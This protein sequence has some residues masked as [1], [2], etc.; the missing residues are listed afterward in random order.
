MFFDEYDSEADDEL[1]I[2]PDVELFGNPFHPHMDLLHGDFDFDD[3]GDIDFDYDYYS[4]EDDEYFSDDE[5]HNKIFVSL[6]DSHVLKRLC[7]HRAFAPKRLPKARVARPETYE[8]L[9]RLLTEIEILLRTWKKRNAHALTAH[10]T[11]PNDP[12]APD[13]APSASPAARASDA[14]AARLPIDDH[15]DDAQSNRSL[16]YGVDYG[17]QDFEHE[18]DSEM[19][20]YGETETN[21][22]LTK[23]KYCQS[24]RMF[25]EAFK[26]NHDYETFYRFIH[27]AKKQV[28]DLIFTLFLNSVPPE[29]AGR[30]PSEVWEKIWKYTQVPTESKLHGLCSGLRTD[31]L[32]ESERLTDLFAAAGDLH[33][34]IFEILFKHPY[35]LDP[36]LM[37]DVLMGKVETN[38]ASY[39]SFM[40][41]R[42]QKR[43][44]TAFH[45]M[46]GFH[47]LRV[48]PQDEAEHEDI[49]NNGCEV[50]EENVQ[51]KRMKE[52]LVTFQSRKCR[53]VAPSN[54]LLHLRRGMLDIH[55]FILTGD[56][57]QN[58]IAF[59]E[60]SETGSF[61]TATI[62]NVILSRPVAK[63]HTGLTLLE[64]FMDKNESMP[65]LLFSLA[66]GRFAVANRISTPEKDNVEIIMWEFNPEGETM[67]VCRPE[68]CS[69]KVCDE[70]AS[71]PQPYESQDQFLNRRPCSLHVLDRKNN[72]RVD[73]MLCHRNNFSM[74][75]TLLFYDGVS[76][77]RLK[78]A[79]IKFT[80][81]YLSLECVK[82]GRAILREGNQEFFFLNLNSGKILD[83]YKMADLCKDANHSHEKDEVLDR[84]YYDVKMD[85][86]P[87]RN[88]F[89]I[90]GTGLTYFQLFQYEDSE[91][92]DGEGDQSDLLP[93][94]VLSGEDG[95][96]FGWSG[97]LNAYLSLYHGCIYGAPYQD[98]HLRAHTGDFSR[99]EE[100]VGSVNLMVYDLKT[101][102]LTPALSSLCRQSSPDTL[103]TCSKLLD[104]VLMNEYSRHVFIDFLAH[105]YLY[106]VNPNVMIL[107]TRQGF[108]QTDFHSSHTQAIE[109]EETILKDIYE[110]RKLTVKEKQ[111]LAL[112]QLHREKPLDEFIGTVTLW[113]HSFGFSKLNDHPEVGTVFIHLSAINNRNK[114]QLMSPGDVVKFRI[115]KSHD[116]KFQGV[117][118]NLISS[119]HEA[120][121]SGHR[122]SHHH[123]RG[124]GGRRGGGGGRGGQKSGRGSGASVERN[125]LKVE[126]H[127]VY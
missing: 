58:V 105:R 49:G 71:A 111:I 33:M 31:S 118:V 72:G 27:R 1:Y 53:D 7:F 109:L 54:N 83:Q 81:R 91:Q 69:L 5:N 115:Y 15:D 93:E 80:D 101:R 63:I 4:D 123:G 40:F 73:L 126:S 88:E 6:Q 106:F 20:Y 98:V 99:D 116:G 37:A 59:F 22:I 30:L 74:S 96:I 3:I 2:Y 70:L 43:F 79:T 78:D 89:L 100:S 110:S 42:Y 44:Q 41:D 82:G 107:A 120:K 55:E 64:I 8:D 85:Q 122:H 57:S 47:N 90:F 45:R 95:G 51:V 36:P 60:V 35:I 87:K 10:I 11:R 18:S 97:V 94:V 92:Q 86:D 127:H 113:K 77:A 52:G 28:Y 114:G 24:K 29:T 103:L 66:H 14:T 76:G 62:W 75:T 61:I 17:T 68:D 112:T 46:A 26:T 19:E 9:Y 124:R 104:Q 34:T 117:D 39:S 38:L 65:Y 13:L 84:C 108:I 21:D 121:K 125:A 32:V 67:E 12:D 56:Q 119:V 50:E 48:A 23:K 16:R 102:E 25:I